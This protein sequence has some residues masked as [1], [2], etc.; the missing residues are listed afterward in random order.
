MNRV[1][2]LYTLKKGTN[3]RIWLLIKIYYY[4]NLILY[5][6][7]KNDELSEPLSAGVGVQARGQHVA[8][9]F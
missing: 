8:L 7:G 4:Q 5:L 1:K 3:P 6:S 9:A 2:L